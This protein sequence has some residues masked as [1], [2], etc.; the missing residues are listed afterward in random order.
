VRPARDRRA[1]ERT[2]TEVGIYSV[3]PAFRAALRPV[4]GALVRGGISADAVTLA[5][6][7][8]AAVGGLGVWLGRLGDAWLLLVPLGAFLRTA[9]NALDG[10]VAQATGTS[11]PVGEV[12]NETVDRLADVAV[13]LPIGLV[14]GVHP[15]LVAGAVAAMMTVSFLGVTVKAAGGPRVYSGIMGKPDR[16]LVVGAA[17]IV[18][19]WVDPSR[20]FIWALWIVVA[21]CVVTLVQRAAVA[22]RA[23]R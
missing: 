22:A 8:F 9:A 18:A 5:G 21:G 3:K 10:L 17:A 16:M 14:P 11:R 1:G 23:L 2:L 13:F 19:L 6:L 7:V 15:L 20:V 4:V 12:L